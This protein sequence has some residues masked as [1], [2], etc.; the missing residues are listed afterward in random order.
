MLLDILSLLL[1]GHLNRLMEHIPNIHIDSCFLF[2]TGCFSEAVLLQ[3]KNDRHALVINL[4]SILSL[5]CSELVAFSI[6]FE[7][8]FEHLD[9]REEHCRG[10]E[11]LDYLPLFQEVWLA[12]VLQKILQEFRCGF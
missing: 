8:L 2:R 3:Q 9:V 12:L 1:R 5:V 7:Q 4:G 11:L 6:D 10:E